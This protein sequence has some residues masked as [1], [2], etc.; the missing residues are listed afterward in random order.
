MLQK[1]R[2]YI[3]NQ[4]NIRETLNNFSVE[5]LQILSVIAQNLW[6]GRSTARDS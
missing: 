2:S 6:P 3:K 1:S 4:G 5:V